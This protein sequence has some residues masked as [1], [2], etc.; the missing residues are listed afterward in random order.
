MKLNRWT[1]PLFKAT[2]A[3]PSSPVAPTAS[4]SPAAFSDTEA[5]NRS[6]ASRADTSTFF[7]PEYP[8]PIVASSDPLAKDVSVK[9]N[10]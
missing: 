4:R 10:R 1:A 5:P 7:P 3:R 9:L 8:L 6:D 2:L